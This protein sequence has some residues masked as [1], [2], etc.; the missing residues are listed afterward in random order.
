M[1][2]I[3]DIFNKILDDFCSSNGYINKEVTE[4]DDFIKTTI[5]V[6]DSDTVITT[7]VL[8][9]KTKTIATYQG[10]DKIREIRYFYGDENPHK[11]YEILVTEMSNTIA[12]EYVK[13]L[14]KES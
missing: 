6:I 4:D 13:K 7:I 11:T 12:A 10:C 5:K 1:N 9:K 2:N 14:M 8:D 3:N